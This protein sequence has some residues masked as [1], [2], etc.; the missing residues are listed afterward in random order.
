[1]A[2]VK[3]NKS[4]PDFTLQDFNGDLVKLSDFQGDKHVVLIFNRGFL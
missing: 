3:I 1:M 2:K 4:A